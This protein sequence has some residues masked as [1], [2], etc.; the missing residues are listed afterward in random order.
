MNVF[1]SW[2]LWNSSV[3]FINALLTR[4][5]LRTVAD[6]GIERTL[7]LSSVLKLS[8][9]WKGGSVVENTDY[10][11]RGSQSHS[12]HPH[13]GSQQSVAT[14]PGI[15][16]PLWPLQALHADNELI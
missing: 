1:D 12:Q 7:S 8:M 3:T 5:Y 11:P 2:V 10:S 15:L 4:Q 13:G 16:H 9:D 6:S 14:T